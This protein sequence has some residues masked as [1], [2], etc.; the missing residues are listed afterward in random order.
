MIKNF[1]GQTLDHL[2]QAIVSGRYPPETAVPPEPV[3]CEELG[4]SRTVV[5]EAVKSL[6]AKGLVSTGPK[7]GTRVLP[8]QQW[9][10]FDPDVIV[11]QSHAGL[12][13]EF[14]RDLQ[15][16]R[17]VVEPAAVRIAAQRRT[18]DDIAAIEAAFAGMKHAVEQGG[19][20][21]KHDLQFHQGLLKASH[22]RMMVQMSKAL[23]ALLRTSF[24]ISTTRKDGPRLSLPLH[25]EVLDAVVAGD[26]ERAERASLVLIDGARADIDLVLES[27]KPLPRLDAPARRLRAA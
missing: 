8:P 14:L 21:V 13:R 17:R 15:E 10:W 1:H 9:N 5:R 23:S 25:R 20:Y 26:A 24:E 3:L 2:G 6:V 7:V 11:W 22:N 18:A 12:T 4:V 19:D 27:R 16:L